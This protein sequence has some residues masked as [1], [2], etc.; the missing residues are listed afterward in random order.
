MANDLL[1]LKSFPCNPLAQAGRP[2]RRPGLI[3]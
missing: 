1:S 3:A 2:I